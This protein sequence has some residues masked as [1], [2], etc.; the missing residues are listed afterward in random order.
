MFHLGLVFRAK[1]IPMGV[2]ASHVAKGLGN[3]GDEENKEA[4]K[5]SKN[6]D[7]GECC[8]GGC[9]QS[10][11]FMYSQPVPSRLFLLATTN[12]SFVDAVHPGIC[13]FY[14]D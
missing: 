9:C 6:R 11:S 7:V 10:V 8:A 12:L 3:K 2:D 5:V 1:V 13:G 4:L 14:F